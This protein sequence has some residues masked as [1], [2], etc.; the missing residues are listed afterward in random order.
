MRKNSKEPQ[1][2]SKGGGL[3]EIDSLFAQKKQSDQKIQQQIQ[4]EKQ[5]AKEERA[6]IKQARLEEEAEEMALRGGA[7]G[8]SGVASS[9]AA[10]GKRKGDASAP[11][12]LQAKAKKLSSLTYTRSDIMELNQSNDKEAKDVWASDGLGGIFNGEGYT[13]RRD[14]G[15]HRVF[16][17]HLMN[18]KDFGM[19]KD[20]PFDCDCC[21]I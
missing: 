20:C 18:K 17:A 8:V 3:E 14:D 7:T 12:A 21:F 4:N 15:G 11:Q 1:S 9:S 10:A 5:I 16:K 19:T 2:S 13:G 6:R